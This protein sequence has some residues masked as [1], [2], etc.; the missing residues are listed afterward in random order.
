VSVVKQMGLIFDQAKRVLCSFVGFGG[1]VSQVG[2][3]SAIVFII[4]VVLMGLFII[5]G[6]QL[7]KATV[8]SADN[9]GEMLSI[10]KARDS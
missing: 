8:D 4:P 5:M 9:T 3:V 6:A 2:G 10:M 7:V 1:S